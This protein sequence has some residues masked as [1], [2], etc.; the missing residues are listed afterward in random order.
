L[1][2]ASGRFDCSPVRRGFR[3]AGL[4]DT[5]RNA[6]RCDRCSGGNPSLSG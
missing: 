6:G 5:H 1:A 3:Y 2:A 4:D